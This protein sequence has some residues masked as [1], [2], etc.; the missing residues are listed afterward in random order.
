MH[1]AGTADRL[2]HVEIDSLHWGPD[3]T[4]RGT[5]E[6]DVERFISG[7]RWVIELQYRKVRPLIASRADTLL[8]LDYPT[9]VKMQRL[10]RR[11]LARRLRRTELWN[12]NVEPPL[13]SVF[14]DHDHI[15]RW[16]WRTRNKLTPV[17]PTLEERF[18]GL[19]V[20]RLGGPRQAEHWLRA[21]RV[22]LQ[23]LV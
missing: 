19:T 21:L 2:S 8:W 11:T 23:R 12:G 13:S 16:G 1:P 4:P 10:I 5:F 6:D 20:V 15:I 22:T 14:T 18:P 7:P 17:I 3:W 9:P